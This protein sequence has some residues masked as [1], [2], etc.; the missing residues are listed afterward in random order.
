MPTSAASFGYLLPTSE[1]VMAQA[2]PD[3]VRLISLGERAEAQGFD[4]L[5]IVSSS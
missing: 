4:S 3:F 5:R 1:L 2:K